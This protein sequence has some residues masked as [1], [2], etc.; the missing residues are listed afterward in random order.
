MDHDPQ[1]HTWCP[2]DPSRC[3]FLPSAEAAIEHVLTHDQRLVAKVLLRERYINLLVTSAI[4]DLERKAEHQADQ[5][6]PDPLAEDDIVYEIQFEGH[7]EP[8]ENKQA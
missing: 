6:L 1:Y 4:D 3:D 8:T 2:I 7:E 5:F